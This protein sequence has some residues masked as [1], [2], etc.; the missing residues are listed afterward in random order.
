MQL[1]NDIKAE[2]L[3]ALHRDRLELPMLPEVA[4]KI[5]DAADNPDISVAELAH[6]IGDDPA[7]AARIVRVSNSPLM[8]GDSSI[9]TLAGAVG[10]MGITFTANLATGFAMEQMFQATSE[11][12]DTL[13]RAVWSHSTRVAA[14]A[15]V[16]AR[17]Y[18]KLKPDRAMLA[19]LTHA[20]GIL[21]V[22]AWAENDDRLGDEPQLLSAVI[23]AVHP[24]LGSAILESW[25][26]PSELIQVP[27]EYCAFAR[28]S[29][30]TDY[31]DVVM[32]AN[33][34]SYLGT[35]HPFGR[36]DWEEI[37]AF[38]RF[39]VAAADAQLEIAEMANAVAAA[40]H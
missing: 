5:R 34:Q 26:F 22:L 1:A 12:V 38:T 10:R 16:V 25:Q 30:A 39:G 4:L 15:T 33:L 2:I 21:P 40:M 18:T 23:E 7:L 20:I 14:T 32:V 13:M 17:R 24:H 36:L 11:T 29:P 3:D 37:A 9:E 28:R 8:R 35:D 6:V 27:L 19:G 31:I